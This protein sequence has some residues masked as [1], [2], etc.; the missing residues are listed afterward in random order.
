MKSYLVETSVIIKYLRGEQ[1]IID[2]LNNFEGELN[3]S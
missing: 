3:S 2:C 1:K